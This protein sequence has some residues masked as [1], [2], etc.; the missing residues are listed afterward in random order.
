[1]L[2][3]S[4]HKLSWPT[5]KWNLFHNK[6]GESTIVSIIVSTNS[7]SHG[8]GKRLNKDPVNK[9]TTMQ[10]QHQLAEGVAVC[11]PIYTCCAEYL[12]T[13]TAGTDRQIDI[14]PPNKSARWTRYCILSMQSGMCVNGLL[15]SL[16]HYRYFWCTDNGNKIIKFRF[17]FESFVQHCYVWISSWFHQTVI[18]QS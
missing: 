16:C 6:T 8:T 17:F 15:S 13:C 14:S 5:L 4:N 18:H 12:P 10:Q 2:T 3:N 11:L 7:I 1:M 9:Q